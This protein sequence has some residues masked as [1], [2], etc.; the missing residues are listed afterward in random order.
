[1]I[2]DGERDKHSFRR[3][4]VR[5]GPDMKLK[6]VLPPRGGFVLTFDR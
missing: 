2:A 6:F 5:V 4:T 3:E 1:L